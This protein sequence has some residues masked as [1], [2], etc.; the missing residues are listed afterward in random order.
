[1]DAVAGGLAMLRILVAAW[2]HSGLICNIDYVYFS[3]RALQPTQSHP[4]FIRYEL[5]SCV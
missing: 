3:A 2:R 4:L 1:M 5:P